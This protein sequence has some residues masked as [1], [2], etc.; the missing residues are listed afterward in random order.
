MIIQVREVILEAVLA[1]WVLV[2]PG[3]PRRGAGQRCHIAAWPGAGSK[4]LAAGNAAWLHLTPW[5]PTPRGGA[6]GAGDHPP[7]PHRG[8]AAPQRDPQPFNSAPLLSL[9]MSRSS[10]PSAARRSERAARPWS[11]R[12]TRCPGSSRTGSRRQVGL[13]GVANIR[14][15]PHGGGSGDGAGPGLRPNAEL[16]ASGTSG[17]TPPA[18]HAGPGLLVGQLLTPGITLSVLGDCAARGCVQRP[19]SAELQLRDRARHGWA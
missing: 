2:V 11:A 6:W 3:Q 14:Q 19:N 18:C 4:V 16:L 7:H 1:G 12:R 8:R 17:P 13:P 15:R 10:R 5:A 9:Q